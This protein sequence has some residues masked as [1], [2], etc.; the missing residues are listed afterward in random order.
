M[1]LKP[2]NLFIFSMLAASL[3][4]AC[5][6]GSVTTPT[7]DNTTVVFSKPENKP[8]VDADVT[9]LGECNA[10]PGQW[11]FQD[12]ATGAH[13][14]PPDIT[15]SLFQKKFVKSWGG[16]T[17][18]H[19]VWEIEAADEPVWNEGRT[20]HFG[21]GG[22]FTTHGM[23]HSIAL[24]G[25]PANMTMLLG[26]S[27]GLVIADV[28][29]DGTWKLKQQKIINVMGPVRSVAITS[30][31]I[32]EK[33][34]PYA[35]MVFIVAGES[36]Y[37]AKLSDLRVGSGCVAIAYQ[38]KD[39]P[40]DPK[41]PANKRTFRPLKVVAQHTH[42]AFLTASRLPEEFANVAQ[43]KSVL[44]N[45]WT[46]FQSTAYLIDLARQTP[47][48]PIITTMGEFDRFF[49]SDISAEDTAIYLYG[50]RYKSS[51][52]ATV[53]SGLAIYK[54]LIGT[55]I[56]ASWA[57][58]PATIGGDFR[59]GR[60]DTNLATAFI[61]GL[62]KAAR[63][64]NFLS[65]PTQQK[66]TAW[67][68]AL[69]FDY[70]RGVS[71]RLS[72][73][74]NTT[75]PKKLGQ[76]Q[77]DDV[78][79][80]TSQFLANGPQSRNWVQLIS[81][82]FTYTGITQILNATATDFDYVD[83]QGRIVHQH[84]QDDAKAIFP[85]FED[86]SDTNRFSPRIFHVGSY[87]FYVRHD[88]VGPTVHV[89]QDTILGDVDITGEGVKGVFKG[90]ALIRFNVSDVPKKDCSG[91]GICTTT[92]IGAFENVQG[93][94]SNYRVDDIRMVSNPKLPNL[95]HFIMLVHHWN[96]KTN[97]YRAV[98]LQANLSITDNSNRSMEIQG[99][100]DLKDPGNN[101]SWN[102]SYG[103]P[104]EQPRFL[105][106]LTVTSTSN[107]TITYS[108]YF[109]HYSTTYNVWSINLKVSTQ[110]MPEK[111]SCSNAGELTPITDP[112]AT[113]SMA[114]TLNG[115]AIVGLHGNGLVRW[116][117]DAKTTQY[118]DVGNNLL[119]GP[120]TLQK[121][122]IVSAG[123]QF[124]TQMDTTDGFHPTAVFSMDST[125]GESCPSCQFTDLSTAG[126]GVI[127]AHPERGVEFY[128]F[129]Q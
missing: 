85:L 111:S 93:S 8:V 14:T 83:V 17:T 43:F 118:Y 77:W 53:E 56:V 40:V 9:T 45:E 120:V 66:W 24:S 64:D 57:G 116:K 110:V 51:K 21:S 44:Q 117:L 55:P 123:T 65:G 106:P 122:R 70:V 31:V 63:V 12:V 97:D 94:A 41:D 82:G 58:V 75:D 18:A 81:G 39:H 61:R 27:D 11:E 71:Y 42:A 129:S 119:G 33:N 48:E 113:E 92:A 95:Q 19:A 121:G 78:S 50:S 108:G 60:F 102:S 1:G 73:E 128:N 86:N 34:G 74:K 6:G 104:D 89:F 16:T 22:S 35:P 29:R 87:L 38:A 90:P 115:N 54:A 127:A 10:L 91:G 59:M 25:T 15:T 32:L 125:V 84:T 36:V 62:D 2:K 46:S 99:C 49:A 126:S 105:A 68:E 4:A 112:V 109:Q 28:I 88:K 7:P 20:V 98:A 72:F 67:K 30:Q 37:V 79:V 103:N 107:D 26:T 52:P 80:E 100:S 69:P 114:A 76:D 124:I 13:M 96:G 3:L 5:G 47:V 23:I 101:Y